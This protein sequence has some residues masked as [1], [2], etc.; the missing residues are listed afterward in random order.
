[1]KKKNKT[2]HYHKVN[3]IQL[4]QT[5]AC[6]QWIYIWTTQPKHLIGSLNA[7]TF[8]NCK[9]G[10]GICGVR[11][12]HTCAEVLL[13]FIYLHLTHSKYISMSLYKHEAQNVAN[14]SA[15]KA[16]IQLI[17]RKEI[18]AQVIKKREKT[19]KKRVNKTNEINWRLYLMSGLNV[20]T[21]YKVN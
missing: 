11:A 15:G 9:P 1:M 3:D 19:E 2:R 5:G 6:W 8:P 17:R 14:L 18:S 16:D 21:S 7:I 12:E 13:Y 20:C 4:N 10:F